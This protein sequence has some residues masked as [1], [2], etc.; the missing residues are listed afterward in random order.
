MHPNSEESF[1]VIEGSLEVAM[2]G[3]W[4]SV[5]AGEQATVPAGVPHTLRNATDEP[6]KMVT[7]VQPAGRSEEFFRD[8]HRLI[9]EAGWCAAPCPTRRS[10]SP[11]RYSFAPIP[12]GCD[13]ADG[14]VS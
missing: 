14:A 7:I 13:R 9:Q 1:E 4:S 8:L 12:V 10:G 11:T 6:I 2:D 5:Q 3:E